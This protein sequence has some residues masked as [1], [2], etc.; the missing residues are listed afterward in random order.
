MQIFFN[1]LIIA[2]GF[3]SLTAMVIGLWVM[4]KEDLPKSKKEEKWV[5]F[6]FATPYISGYARSREDWEFMKSIF[7]NRN[8]GIT[9]DAIKS[10]TYS[11]LSGKKSFGLFGFHKESYTLQDFSDEHGLNL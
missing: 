6:V 8:G 1:I 2:L 10:D 5:E 4:V 7:I 9:L 3:I 11:A